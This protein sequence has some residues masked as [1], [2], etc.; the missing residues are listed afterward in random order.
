MRAAFLTLD[1]IR[2]GTRVF[3][4]STIFVYHFTQASSDCRDF[5]ERCE[6]RDIHGISSVI[7]VA[8]VAHRLMTIEAVRLGLVKGSNIPKKLRS[9]PEAVSKLRVYQDAIDRIPLMGIAVADL[10]L[11]TFL[12]S[13]EVRARHGLLVN[14]SLV[15]AAAQTAGVAALASADPDFDRVEGLSLYRPG[16][17]S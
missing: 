4:D 6:R 13:R 8:E 1:E 2:P 16:D 12:R 3:V 14:D 7:V 11:A 5:L 15:V 17:L 9:R 10:D